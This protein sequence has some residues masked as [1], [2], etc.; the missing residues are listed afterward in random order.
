[1][2]NQLDGD[3]KTNLKEYIDLDRQIKEASK[4]LKI[5]K[6]RKKNLSKTINV[7]MKQYSIDELQIPGG[8]IKTVETNSTGG[9]TK[10]IIL[11]RCVLLCNGNEDEGKQMADFI[12]DKSCRPKK[13][14]ST[15]RKYNDRKKK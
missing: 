6:N 3:F 1:M 15:I 5:I 8:K 12:C 4:S 11:E 2:S 14:N 7:Y 9:L 13:K 10:K